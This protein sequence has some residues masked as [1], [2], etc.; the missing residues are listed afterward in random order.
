MFS[1]P[2]LLLEEVHDG[3]ACFKNGFSL[4]R[5]RLHGHDALHELTHMHIHTQAESVKENCAGALHVVVGL[6]MSSLLWIPLPALAGH[7]CLFFF[8]DALSVVCV[9]SYTLQI[10]SHSHN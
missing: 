9:T 6:Q 10:A 5:V 2:L 7:V 8:I 1:L 4:R 3:P